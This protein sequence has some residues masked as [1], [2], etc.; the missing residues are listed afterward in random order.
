MA[1]GCSYFTHINLNHADLSGITF[2]KDLFIDPLRGDIPKLLQQILDML[3]I[4]IQFGRVN[5]GLLHRVYPHGPTMFI[6]TQDPQ[7]PVP[8]TVIF[9]PQASDGPTLAM[10]VNHTVFKSFIFHTIAMFCE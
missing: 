1:F 3:F 9:P 8:P 4:R 7:D 2:L 10:M 6:L 5:S